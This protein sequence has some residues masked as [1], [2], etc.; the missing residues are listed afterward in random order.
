M[1]KLNR[2]AFTLVEVLAA[3]IIIG[4]VALIVTPMILGTIKKSRR[5]TFE[6]SIDGLIE[7]VRIDHSDDNFLA[8]RE[9]YYNKQNLTLLTVNDNSRDEE[10]KIKG[11]IDGSG[12]IYVDEEGNIIINNICNGSF[13]ASGEEGD[14]KI[15]ENET[16]EITQFDKNDPIINLIG[17]SEVYVGLNEEYV[18]QGA[19]ARTGLNHKLE[20]QM[21]IRTEKIEVNRID[22]SKEGTYEITYSATNNEK[23]VSV[24]RTVHVVNMIPKITLTEGNSS[25]VTKQSISMIVSAVK[26]NIINNFSYEIK[27]DGISQGIETVTGTA[28]TIT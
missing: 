13:C 24:K 28:K 2:K 6:R 10:I 15:S 21:I 25:Y 14:I 4:I 5:N 16:G 19:V 11:K 18:E 9:Y 3:I 27:K 20:Y 1:R 7:S 23:T 8:P 12:F 22:T 26:P 17:N